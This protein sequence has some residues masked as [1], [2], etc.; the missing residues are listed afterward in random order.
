MNAIPKSL[1]DYNEGDIYKNEL[2]TR[3]YSAKPDYLI[4]EGNKCGEVTVATENKELRRRCSEIGTRIS[5]ITEYLVTKNQKRKFVDQIGLAFSEAIEGNIEEAQKILDKLIERIELYKGN[6]GKFYYLISCLGVVLIAIILSYLLNKYK[7]IPEIIP[8][9]IIMT[10]AAIGGFL[11]TAKD[12]R[13]IHIDSSDFGWFQ[14]FYGST[15]I[16][17]SMFSGLIIYVLVKSEIV[18]PNLNHENNIYVVYILAI[19]AGFS[20]SMI[21]NLLKKVEKTNK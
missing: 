21:P 10:Y 15:R 4:F 18:L 3:L 6:L 7:F 11:S 12:L 8:H 16:L 17:I 14:V 19:A 20:E 9:F 1:A 5:V 13:K 2:I